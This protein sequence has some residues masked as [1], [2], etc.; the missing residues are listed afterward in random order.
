MSHLSFVVLP[1]GASMCAGLSISPDCTDLPAG[2][3]LIAGAKDGGG[4]RTIQTAAQGHRDPSENASAG[5]KRSH[6]R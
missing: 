5:E 6:P 4:R 3:M 1:V 2:F